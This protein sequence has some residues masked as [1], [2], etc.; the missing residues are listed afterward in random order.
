MNTWGRILFAAASL[1]LLQSAVMAQKPK[2]G[3][4]LTVANSFSRNGFYERNDRIAI[5]GEIVSG[6][7]ISGNGTG[8]IMWEIPEGYN[9]FSC[10][11]GIEDDSHCNGITLDILLDGQHCDNIE[12]Q[13]ERKQMTYNVDVSGKK[14]VRINCKSSQ[15]GWWLVEPRLTNKAGVPPPEPVPPIDG[16]VSVQQSTQAPFVVD[17][18]DIDALASYLRKVVNANSSLK[19]RME[20]GQIALSTFQLIGISSK[21]VADSVAEDLSTAMI[22]EGFELVE[23]GQLDSVLNELKF[24]ATGAVNPKTVKEIGQLSGCDMVVIGS[25]SDRGQFI[26]INC[27][28]LD[29]ETA[30]ALTAKR[31]E[32]RKIPIARVDN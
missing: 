8:W 18:K 17:P 22:E 30:K 21:A 29:A 16:V 14:T 10:K 5:A 12:I 27:R 28:I 13:S 1:V 11:T 24:Q 23:R 31:V 7:K 15:G 6:S 9:T 25:I 2:A 20:Q 4:M 32:M 26:V 3:M 19:A